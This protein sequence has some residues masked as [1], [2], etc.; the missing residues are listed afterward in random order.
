MIQRPGVQELKELGWSE[1]D[2]LGL[3]IGWGVGDA[4]KPP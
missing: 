4:D 3:E 2:N 1:G